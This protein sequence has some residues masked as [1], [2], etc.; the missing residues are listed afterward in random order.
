MTS[1]HLRSFSKMRRW[2]RI[3]MSSF[4]VFPNCGQVCYHKWFIALAAKDI[5]ISMSLQVM[6][7]CQAAS[8]KFQA[9]AAR[10]TVWGVPWE[11]PLSEH[12]EL[13]T[14]CDH[15]DFIIRNF[16]VF[17]PITFTFITFE[18][19]VRCVRFRLNKCKTKLFLDVFFKFN[20]LLN[21]C[22]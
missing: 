8:V 20:K 1:T 15:F 7:Y 17:F 22:F 5:L 10:W 11:W 18:W 13:I 6:S 9:T 16:N 3:W 19:M 12:A 4:I 2:L 21:F 14:K